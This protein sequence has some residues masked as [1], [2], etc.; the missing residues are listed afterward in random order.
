[1]DLGEGAYSRRDVTVPRSPNVASGRNG[2]AG[3][4]VFG[5]E[6][7][8]EPGRGARRERNEGERSR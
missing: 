3:R 8:H 1:M 5:A 4:P 7:E 6:A 2:T